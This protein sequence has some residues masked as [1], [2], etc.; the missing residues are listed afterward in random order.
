MRRLLFASAWV[1]VFAAAAYDAHFAWKYR[2]VLQNWELNPLA[3]WAGSELGLP[4]LFGLKFAGLAYALGLA[5]YCYRRHSPL[6]WPLTLV[7]ACLYCA[8]SLHYV[9]GLSQ[10]AQP[11]RLPAAP[12][13]PWQ[14]PRVGGKSSGWDGGNGPRRG[15]LIPIPSAGADSSRLQGAGG[16]TAPHRTSGPFPSQIIQ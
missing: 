6:Q 7:T 16:R 14:G 12:L 9:T 13:A 15:R 1:F 11:R 8:L 3:R 4:V 10:P 5:V 2:E